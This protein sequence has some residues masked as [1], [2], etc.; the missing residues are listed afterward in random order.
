LPGARHQAGSKCKTLADLLPGNLCP[1]PDRCATIDEA[2][3]FKVV[4]I[5][6]NVLGR[7]DHLST[8]LDRFNHHEQ[9]FAISLGSYVVIQ[10][11]YSAAPGTA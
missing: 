2:A 1:H 3:P 11:R 8:A 9:A 10:R 7:F 6:G 4:A 5:D